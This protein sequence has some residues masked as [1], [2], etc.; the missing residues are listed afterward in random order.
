M[1]G[2]RNL[3]LHYVSILSLYINSSQKGKT[4]IKAKVIYSIVQTFQRNV[5]ISQL[6]FAR[7]FLIIHV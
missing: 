3:E 7:L 1:R 5:L 2:T 4:N 6:T